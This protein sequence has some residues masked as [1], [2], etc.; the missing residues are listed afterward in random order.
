[1]LLEFRPQLGP[2]FKDRPLEAFC[3]QGKAC[4]PNARPCQTGTG[5]C[6]VLHGLQP[7]P[8]EHKLFVT[9]NFRADFGQTPAD[10][11]DLLRQ[12]VPLLLDPAGRTGAIVP[13]RMVQCGQFRP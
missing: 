9:T 12:S 10:R 5:L 7:I 3:R 2:R 11:V 6:Q 13:W 8:D 1:M 4:L